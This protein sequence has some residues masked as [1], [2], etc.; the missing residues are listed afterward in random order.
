VT[1]TQGQRGGNEACQGICCEHQA[2]ALTWRRWARPWQ[3]CRIVRAG[4]NTASSCGGFGGATASAYQWV[5]RAARRC[6]P[7]PMRRAWHP[8]PRLPS[9]CQALRQCYCHEER[10]RNKGRTARRSAE[11]IVDRF[12]S[13]CIT[14]QIRCAKTT[15][16]THELS[17]F[18]CAVPP[19]YL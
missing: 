4:A 5:R 3:T 12:S 11:V 13:L 9:V 18:S 1:K 15:T 2:L 16:D 17:P 8:R 7:Q 19:S 14:L 6:L 10:R